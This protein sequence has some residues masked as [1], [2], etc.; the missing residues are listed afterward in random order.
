M[1]DWL[2]NDINHAL[3][4]SYIATIRE[5]LHCFL[6][7]GSLLP[8]NARQ[9]RKNGGEWYRSQRQH[10]GLQVVAYRFY[11]GVYLL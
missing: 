1:N 4:D 7:G 9:A 6:V 8:N 5:E 11:I 10:V 3:V 2:C